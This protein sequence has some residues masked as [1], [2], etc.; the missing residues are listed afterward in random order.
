MLLLYYNALKLSTLGIM[1]PFSTA[2][3]IYILFTPL[4]HT[5]VRR[6]L[7]VQRPR[8]EMDTINFGYSMKNIPIPSN[9]KYLFI[10]TQRTERVLDNH[11]HRHLPTVTFRAL[12]TITHTTF[13][14]TDIRLQSRFA[15]SGQSPTPNLT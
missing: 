4:H 7:S 10:L 1:L 12:W 13:R 15:R 5:E 14:A 6:A 2:L 9:N 8:H 3:L 11:L